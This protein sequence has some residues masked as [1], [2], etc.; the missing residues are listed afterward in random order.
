[1][2]II[3]KFSR[4]AL[5]FIFK[6]MGDERG[7]ETIEWAAITAIFTLFVCAIL[8]YFGIIPNPFGFEPSI[9]DKAIPIAL[10]TFVVAGIGYSVKRFFTLINNRAQLF[11]LEILSDGKPR[12]RHEIKEILKKKDRSF[13][14]PEVELDAL[15]DLALNGKVKLDN[16]R[17]TLASDSKSKLKSK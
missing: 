10:L 7:I 3:A 6:L 16:N 15:A 2:R 12:T 11:I 5:K 14:L 8:F 4:D 1:M 13:R 17:Y 9:V